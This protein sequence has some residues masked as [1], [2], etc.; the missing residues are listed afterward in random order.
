[1][2]DFK[3]RISKPSPVLLADTKLDPIDLFFF[4]T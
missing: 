1:M 3:V 2:R 4:L